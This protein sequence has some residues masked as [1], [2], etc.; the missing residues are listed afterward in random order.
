MKTFFGVALSALVLMA[1]ALCEAQNA[2]QAAL[3]A[4]S[5]NSQHP[6]AALDNQDGIHLQPASPVAHHAN[7]AEAPI[8]SSA[9]LVNQTGGNR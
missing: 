2:S 1:P 4:S 3:Y 6:Y 8:D 9:A 7:P 5:Y